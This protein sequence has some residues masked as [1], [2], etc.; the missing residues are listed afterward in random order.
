I[1]NSDGPQK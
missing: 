1:F